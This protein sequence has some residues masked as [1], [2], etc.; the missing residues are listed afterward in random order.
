MI[1]LQGLVGRAG[2]FAAHHTEGRR[3]RRARIWY[4]AE[5]GRLLPKDTAAAW[6]VRRLRGAPA[7]VLTHTRTLYLTS[8]YADETWPTE[9]R[10]Q[11]GFT[12]DELAARIG[13]G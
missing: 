7:R 12:A 1:G 6:A 9:L 5:T 2:Q 4:T 11:V 3:R 10:E 8:T 13:E